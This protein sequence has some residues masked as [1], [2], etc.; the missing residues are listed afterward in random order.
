MEV[1]LAACLL[2]WAAGAQSE[3]A[4]L[5]ISPAQRAVMRERTRHEKAV[6]KIAE[7]H[8]TTASPAAG[9][10]T[11]KEKEGPAEGPLT[12]PE[13]FRA[14]Y[15]GRTPVA[16]V[17]TPVGRRAGDLT[18][19]GV[20]WAK[21][22][23]RSAVREFRKRRTAAGK[24]D[25]APLLVP[26][27][28]DR[29]PLVPPMPADPPT[30]GGTE[31][32]G[33][34]LTKPETASEP[35]GAEKPPEA[36]SAPAADAKGPEGGPDAP[37]AP[38]GPSE[39]PVAASVPGPRSAEPAPAEA[40]PAPATG[41]EQT[42]AEGSPP[43]DSGGAK[44]TMDDK[45]VGRMAA[46]VSFESVM[47]ESD[48]LSLMC[49]DDVTVYARVRQRCEREIGRADDLL[50]QLESVG[51]GAGVTG[52]VTRCREQYQL[53][54]SQLD[55]LESN[56]L[57]QAEAVVKAKALLEAGQ[58]VYADIAAD[59]ESVAERTFYTSDAVDGEDS[60]AH[61]ETFE[62]QGARA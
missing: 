16:R 27:P 56:T 14:G 46:E 22:T 15:R 35:E 43:A 53:I 5:G 25:P 37:Q 2:A 11:W 12:L 30:A 8:G 28:P 29:P 20:V 32:A 34:V 57:A 45:G 1:L 10:S 62:T 50:A 21:D 9:I 52:W 48:E 39:G 17:A 47:D 38:Q 3:Q 4:K 7:K 58:G 23:G 19:R 24:P 13:A 18:A 54:H 31:P 59:M 6:R 42:P 61:S 33:V 26:P 40:D 55:A 41:T 60:A 49:D 51:A 44:P 36:A